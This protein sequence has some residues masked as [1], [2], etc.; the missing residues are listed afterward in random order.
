M[1][2]GA[3]A[4]AFIEIEGVGAIEFLEARYFRKP[5]R[6]GELREV[7]AALSVHGNSGR[8]ELRDRIVAG[9]EVLLTQMPAMAPRIV[10]DLLAW[11]RWEMGEAVSR[12]ADRCTKSLQP[13]AIG[14]LRWFAAIAVKARRAPVSR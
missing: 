1:Q 8:T 6:V 2:L 7:V 11:R 10:G 14:K 4:T 12:A 3:W 13:D 5:R 9:Y